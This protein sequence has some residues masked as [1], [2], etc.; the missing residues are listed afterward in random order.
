[1]LLSNSKIDYSSARRGPTVK[2]SAQ[3]QGASNPTT[4]IM[5]ASTSLQDINSHTQKYNWNKDQPM[6]NLTESLLTSKSNPSSRPKT[7]SQS[8]DH[9]FEHPEITIKPSRTDDR[10]SRRSLVTT[11]P[12]T[13]YESNGGSVPN[14]LE[15]PDMKT[16][17]VMET[18]QV[19]LSSSSSSTPSSSHHNNRK[20]IRQQSADVYAT[21]TRTVS[22]ASRNQHQTN[23]APNQ[24]RTDSPGSAIDNIMESPEQEKSEDSSS[25]SLPP[26]ATT[27]GA[28]KAP[29][30][31]VR[32]YSGVSSAS[33]VDR[34]GKHSEKTN[35]PQSEED[36]FW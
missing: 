27:T 14:I 19:S 12:M 34:T 36:D 20:I 35:K 30:Q 24:R 13:H 5:P 21:L 29:V 31:I 17:I 22:P 18:Q 7:F 1:M 10:A 3:I 2:L 4:N 6:I 8:N 9:I 23:A 16:P 32:E 25:F 15:H 26:P 33:D 11:K 28:T